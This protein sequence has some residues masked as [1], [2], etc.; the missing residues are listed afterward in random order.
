L[1]FKGI[2]I[3]VASASVTLLY[4]ALRRTGRGEVQLVQQQIA[5]QSRMFRVGRRR[6]F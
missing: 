3:M 2:Y 5:R 1:F 4:L 6:T